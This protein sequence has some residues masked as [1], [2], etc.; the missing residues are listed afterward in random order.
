MNHETLILGFTETN[1]ADWVDRLGFPAALLIAFGLAGWRVANWASP[2]VS[3]IAENQI[4]FTKAIAAQAERS[5]DLIEKLIQ[6][7]DGQERL[8]NEI[9][10]KVC[11][12]S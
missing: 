12:G 7:I 6:R 3:R 8:I 2:I 10:T 5:A 4:E 9:H 1:V 11:R